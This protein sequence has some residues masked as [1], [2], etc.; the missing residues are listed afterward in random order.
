MIHVCYAIYD[1]RGTYSKFVGASI[2]SLFENTREPVTIHILHDE[3][4]NEENRRKFNALVETYAQRIEFHPI[5]LDETVAEFM[6][7][8]THL[9]PA[10]F[11]RFFISDL[12]PYSR[13]IYL[14]ADLLVNLDIKRLWDAID[15]DDLFGAVPDTGVLKKPGTYKRFPILVDGTVEREKYFNSGVLVINLDKLRAEEDFSRRAIKLFGERTDYFIDNDQ[16]LYNYFFS[17]QYR[18]IDDDFNRQLVMERRLGEPHVG[19]AIW[20]YI[21]N[22]VGVDPNDEFDRLFWHYFVKTPW[23]DE[24]FFLNA[25]REFQSSVAHQRMALIIALNDRR[26]N[27]FWRPNTL[28]EA[29]LDLLAR[30]SLDGIYLD[31][32]EDRHYASNGGKRPIGI[33]DKIVVDNL[34]EALERSEA[35]VAF[36]T[37][38]NYRFAY[39]TLTRLGYRE[40]VDFFDARALLPDQTGRFLSN[41]FDVIKK[42]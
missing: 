15:E 1:A 13:A 16:G 20:H 32:E 30:L 28:R 31:N 23:F 14:D 40:G 41:D 17:E 35:R 11:Y 5:E 29:S 38:A 26:Q 25:V 27:I 6:R 7:T 3:T 33:E 37:T 34:T 36:L 39:F 22:S 18:R 19:E 24:R 4:L 12:L 42:L 9:S 2:C 21:N 8:H 10:A